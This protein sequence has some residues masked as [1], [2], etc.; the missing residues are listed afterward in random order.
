MNGNLIIRQT[1]DGSTTLF[2]EG[3]NETYHSIHGALTESR[4]VF[5]EKGVRFAAEKFP[6]TILEILE[7]GFGTGLNA[8]L[9]LEFSKSTSDKIMYTSI[10]KFP[11]NESVWRILQFPGIELND[12]IGIHQA[13]WN[14]VVNFH[15]NFDLLKVEGDAVE[16]RFPAAKF[17]VIYFDAF[18]PG[19]QPELWTP[20]IFS[21]LYDALLPGGFL[22]TYCAK[23]QFKRDLRSSG[24]TV[25]S[26]PGPPG[27]REMVRAI[28]H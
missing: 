28:R 26:L 19:K 1:A 25:E 27:K 18:A 14:I 17:H 9:T 13:P 22:V 3:L 20:E 21:G 15:P 11:L 6:K 4:H 16:E 2:H 12:L 10:E 23:G 8:C 7:I 5:I 24:F